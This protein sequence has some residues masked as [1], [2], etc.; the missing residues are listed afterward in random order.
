MG[1]VGVLL[2]WLDFHKPGPTG[3]WKVGVILAGMVL[4]GQD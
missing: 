4:E 2:G 1:E 3:A